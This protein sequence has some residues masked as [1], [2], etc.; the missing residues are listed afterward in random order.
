MNVRTLRSRAQA[1]FTLIE[2]MI[3]VA[4]IGILAAIAIPQYQTYIAKSQVSRAVGETGAIKT[5][6]EDCMNNGKTTIGAAAGECN[7]GATASS[8]LSG[9]PQ[10]GAPTV[11]GAGYP[12][13]TITPASGTAQIVGTFGNKAANTLTAGT[14]KAITWARDANGTWTCNSTADVKYNTAACG[15]TVAATP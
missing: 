10:A 11:A 5:A 1:G 12:V 13:V 8:I 3:V 4:I 6:I 7:P 15:A 9:T 2:L 14:A